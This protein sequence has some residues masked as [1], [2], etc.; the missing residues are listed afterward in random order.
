VRDEDFK[1]QL[2]E[3]TENSKHQHQAHELETIARNIAEILSDSSQAR[4]VLSAAE[5]IR[6]GVLASAMAIAPRILRWAAGA[7]VRSRR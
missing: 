1:E 3:L 5:L 7:S 2:E 4:L 6:D